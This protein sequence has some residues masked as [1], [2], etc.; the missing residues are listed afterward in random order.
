[1]SDDERRTDL[2]FWFLVSLSLAL[3]LGFTLS[4]IFT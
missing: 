2:L 4:Q 1:M 3:V